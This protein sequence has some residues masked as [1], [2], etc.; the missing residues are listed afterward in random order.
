MPERTSNPIFVFSQVRRCKLVT[1]LQSKDIYLILSAHHTDS[2]PLK[3][4][5]SGKI[6]IIKQDSF[7]KPL[8]KLPNK[9]Q[10]V[11]KAKEKWR[12]R[13]SKT[14]R[15]KMCSSMCLKITQNLLLNVL[16]NIYIEIL[17]CLGEKNSSG[18]TSPKKA[19]SNSVPAVCR[20]DVQGCWVKR[21]SH[22]GYRSGSCSL[23]GTGSLH[24]L[25]GLFLSHAAL[26]H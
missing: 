16:L 18:Q 19:D 24:H 26:S 13:G 7:L 22:S 2:P 8:I 21:S 9:S 6:K 5:T 3:N 11:L 12:V 15:S 20:S 25:L 23:T 4:Q 1:P 14:A 17:T 10:F